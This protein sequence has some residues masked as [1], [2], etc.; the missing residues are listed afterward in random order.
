MKIIK[1]VLLVIVVSVLTN[2]VLYVVTQNMKNEKVG[3]VRTA[4]VLSNYEAM[5]HSNQVYEKE[6]ARVNANIDTLRSRYQSLKELLKQSKAKKRKDVEHRLLIAEDDYNRYTGKALEQL[7]QRRLQLTNKVILEINSII[8]DYGKK[9]GFKVILGATDD[10]SILYGD[11][12]FDVTEEILEVLNAN[13]KGQ[14]DN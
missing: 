4:Y 12:S 11:T 10:G 5:I 1:V 7:E 8:E 13:Y 3:F 9:K 14:N 2:I 6:S